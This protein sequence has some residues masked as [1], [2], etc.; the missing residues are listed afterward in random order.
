MHGLRQL[1]AVLS[2]R[3]LVPRWRAPTVD[4]V[5]DSIFVGC[6]STR[7]RNRNTL[8]RALAR[9]GFRVVRP[10]V[11][12]T[13][14]CVWSS[15]L[16]TCTCTC[17]WTCAQ[18]NNSTAHVTHERMHMCAGITEARPRDRDRA[19]RGGVG[20]GKKPPGTLH[21][22]NAAGPGVGP[23]VGP[24]SGLTSPARGAAG[25]GSTLSLPWAGHERSL[26]SSADCGVE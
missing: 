6:D 13:V 19:A 22:E 23:G 5:R 26:P 16:R 11:R 20:V 3:A 2:A 14:K 10:C 8:M 18:T 25:P 9:Y 4:L 24:G 15:E 1:S 7:L 17:S 12:W 21:R